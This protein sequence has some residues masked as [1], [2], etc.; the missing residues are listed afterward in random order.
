MS[1]FKDVGL[2]MLSQDSC[3]GSYQVEQDC[4]KEEDSSCLDL[5]KEAHPGLGCFSERL[6]EIDF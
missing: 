3:E 5:E 6:L 4:A 2:S 1:R